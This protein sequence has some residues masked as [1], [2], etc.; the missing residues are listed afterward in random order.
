MKAKPKEITWD[1]LADVYD[2]CMGGCKARTLP[3]NKV[4]DWAVN[5]KDI[6]TKTRSGGLVLI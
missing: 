5:R 4:F 3:M 1:E 2:K 6:F